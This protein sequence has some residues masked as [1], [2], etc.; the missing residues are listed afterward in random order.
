[1]N[2]EQVQEMLNYIDPILV[3]EADRPLRRRMARPVR[4]GLIAACLCVVLV[5]A[6]TAASLIGGFHSLKFFEGLVFDE[7]PE[8]ENYYEGLYNGYTVEGGMEFVALS[9]LPQETLDTAAE[10]PASTVAVDVHSW[11]EAE[12]YFALELPDNAW[13]DGVTQTSFRTNL[14]SDSVGPTVLEC[15][16]N[17]RDGDVRLE[18]N[19]T[20]YTERMY[21]P[22]YE[23]FQSAL[24]PEGTDFTVEERGYDN[25]LSVL[26]TVAEFSPEDELRGRYGERLYRAHFA[27]GGVWYWVDASCKE[28]PERALESLETLLNS[29]VL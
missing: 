18:V 14:S 16:T 6:V 7:Y 22:D 15:R 25:G 19:V 13:L 17:Y 1:M 2:G 23:V 21:H 26:L 27:V 4:I 29:F 11:A 28:A 8:G 3:E 10:H 9:D 24:F 5:G 20:A 12:E